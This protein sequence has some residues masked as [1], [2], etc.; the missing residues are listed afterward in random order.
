[1]HCPQR[2]LDGSIAAVTES[3]FFD[4]AVKLGCV[5]LLTTDP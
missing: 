5:A 2:W 3:R 1:M 4:R